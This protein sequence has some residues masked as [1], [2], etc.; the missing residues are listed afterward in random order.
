MAAES[1]IL[2]QGGA[3][4]I[5]E[6]DDTANTIHADVFIRAN[7]IEKIAQNIELPPGTE[8]IDC[9]NKIVAPGFVDTH[10]HMYTIGLRGRHG[11]D[12]LEDYLVR[13]TG[14]TDAASIPQNELI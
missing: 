13:G 9:S 11:N 3:V 14:I 12:L 4:V 10:R 8:V 7:Q 6:E 1:R 5:H 2:L